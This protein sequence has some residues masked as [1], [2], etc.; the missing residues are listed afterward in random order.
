MLS[1]GPASVY[2]S[3]AP[4][5]R[6]ELLEGKLGF[7]DVLLVKRKPLN[8]SHVYVYHVEGFRPGGGLYIFSPNEAGGDLKCIFDAGEGMITT[9]DLSYDGTEV[10]FA[11]RRGGH[12]GSNPVAHIEDISCYKDEESNYHIF[13]INIDGS[14]LRQ[15]TNNNQAGLRVLS[16][17]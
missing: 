13:K 2:E 9:A 15:V 6:R 10:V 3:G 16:A 5:L 14:G 4:A 1:G 12:I 8:I 11:L 17:R 7:K